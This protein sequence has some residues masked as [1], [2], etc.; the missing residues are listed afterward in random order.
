[1]NVV[2]SVLAG[3][4]NQIRGGE[5]TSGQVNCVDSMSP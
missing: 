2:A 4:R 3:L 5:G 1:M